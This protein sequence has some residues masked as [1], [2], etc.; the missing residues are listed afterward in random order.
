LEGASLADVDLHRG[1]LAISGERFV[2]TLPNSYRR[3]PHAF[4]RGGSDAASLAHSQ[5][6]SAAGLSRPFGPEKKRRR[7]EK[8]GSV[9]ESRRIAS[10]YLN[11]NLKRL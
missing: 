11:Q 4:G 6:F 1:G 9:L 3:A 2:R 5:N 10:D 8:E 7:E